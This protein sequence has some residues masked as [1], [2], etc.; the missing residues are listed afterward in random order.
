MFRW[1]P[2]ESNILADSISRNQASSI[3]LQD[4]LLQLA[5]R[6]DVLDEE[7]DS[8]LYSTDTYFGARIKAASENGGSYV[9]NSAHFTVAD[10]LLYFRA[11]T[12]QTQ[13]LC[14]PSSDHLKNQI[15]FEHHDSAASGHPGQRRTQLK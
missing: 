8:L 3:S 9:Q 5:D 13:R 10:G 12:K 7:V 11:T 1:I 15:I 2:G 14:V 6:K 4:L